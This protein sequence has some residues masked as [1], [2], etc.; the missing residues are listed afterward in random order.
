MS[1]LST[2]IQ[3]HYTQ[4]CRPSLYASF[5]LVSSQDGCDVDACPCR[6]RRTCFMRVHPVGN[7]GG[8]KNC[9]LTVALYFEKSYGRSDV[10][11]FK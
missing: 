7:A 11:A 4:A 2:A 6:A 1:H 5:N 3:S 10:L 8:G 9:M